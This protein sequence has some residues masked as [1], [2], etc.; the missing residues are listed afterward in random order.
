MP[1]NPPSY[2]MPAALITLGGP[3]T[4]E[5]AGA[6]VLRRSRVRGCAGARVRGCAGA[7]VRGCAGAGKIVPCNAFTE[8]G[9]T[10]N[11]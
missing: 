3:V 8:S 2:W 10:E 5:G 9:S 4:F 1:S 6:R 11:R 7:R